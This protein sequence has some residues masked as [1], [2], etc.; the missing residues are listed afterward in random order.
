[1][2]T[3]Y[4]ESRFRL[5]ERDLGHTHAEMTT[6]TTKGTDP[7]ARPLRAD[8]RRNRERVLDAARECFAQNGLDAQVDDIAR[9]AK[10]GVGTV[11]R[12][13]PTKQAL[14]EAIAED[15][16]DRLAT[17]ARAG[18]EDSDPWEGFSTFLRN[19]AQAQAGDR[20]LAEVM[21]AEPEVMCDAANRRADLHEALAALV[22]RAQDAG[23]LRR[24]LVPA[25]VPML[26]CG[27]GRATLAGSSGPTMSPRRY[28][29]IILDGLRAPGSGELPDKPA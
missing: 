22:H 15:H 10:V 3:E 24:D 17:S 20:A 21:A 5:S 2:N 27:V 1:M 19:S 29:E 16:F 12:H 13:F 6:T 23:S 28:V 26:I 25:D 11:Y 9:A 18:L 4:T 14:A 7:A 8:A